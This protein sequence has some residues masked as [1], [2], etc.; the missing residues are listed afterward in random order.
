M[1]ETLRQTT[2]SLL[3]RGDLVNLESP[4]TPDKPLGGHF[5]QGH[6]DG[7][8]LI[9][10]IFGD[11]EIIF[12]IEAGDDI[13]RYVVKKGFV[14]VDGISLTVVERAENYFTVSLVRYTVENT[15]MGIK[16]IGDSF[17]LVNNADQT[18]LILGQDGHLSLNQN[19]ALISNVKDP[20]ANQDA[21]TKA[22]VDAQVISAGA[23]KGTCQGNLLSIQFTA[24]TYDGNLGGVAGANEKCNAEYPGYHFCHENEVYNAGR[25]GCLPNPLQFSF[26]PQGIIDND[27]SDKVVMHGDGTTTTTTNYNCKNGQQI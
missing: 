6:V 2:T 25:I 5:V 24:A 22:Y 7:T 18:N 27:R 15:T 12:S 14:A 26:N 11:G 16:K 3:R 20:I 13:L 8:G 10:S 17:A 19:N 1:P 9:R 4:L 23:P 21:A